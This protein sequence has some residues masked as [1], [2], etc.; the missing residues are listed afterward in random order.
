MQC[1]EEVSGLWLDG[2]GAARA[3]RK[4]WRWGEGCGWRHGEET[5]G[6]GNFA[7]SREYLRIPDPTGKG[8]GRKLHPQARIWA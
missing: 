3:D 7:C 6:D 2:T 4:G 5:Y 8:M 1:K